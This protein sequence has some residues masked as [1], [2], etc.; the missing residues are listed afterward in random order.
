[1]NITEGQLLAQ[2]K[3]LTVGKRLALR[4]AASKGDH[5]DYALLCAIGS[6]ETN[7]HN[8]VGDGGHGRGMFQQD[9][10]YQQSFLS[11]T[12]GCKSGSSIPIYKTALQ[13]GRVPTIGAGAR[14][15][16]QIIE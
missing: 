10:R 14:R 5:I 13:Q 6:R 11:S 4:R 7:L 2:Y 15:C 3:A 16:V 1:M 9:D 8:I 12:R